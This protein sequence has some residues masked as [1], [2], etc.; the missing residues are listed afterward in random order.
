VTSRKGCHCKYIL[1]SDGG[2]ES[3]LKKSRLLALQLNKRA[4]G[5]IV[6]IQFRLHNVIY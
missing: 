6:I 1:V 5:K 3:T 2:M 4:L